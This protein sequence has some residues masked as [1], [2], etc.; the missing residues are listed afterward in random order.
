MTYSEINQAMQAQTDKLNAEYYA[1]QNRPAPKNPRNLQFAL[2]DGIKAIALP[3]ITGVSDKQIEYA[4]SCRANI[5]SD[6]FGADD[7]RPMLDANQDFAD[8][9]CKVITGETSA[10]FWIETSTVALLRSMAEVA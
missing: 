4:A 9:L 8:R 6:I 7:Y 3:A 10:K 2:R 1:S 5:V